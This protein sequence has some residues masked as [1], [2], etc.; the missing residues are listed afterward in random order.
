MVDYDVRLVLYLL[1]V[2]NTIAFIAVFLNPTIL[3]T[4][5]SVFQKHVRKLFNNTG[6][7][8]ITI[9]HKSQALTS[10]KAKQHMYSEFFFFFDISPFKKECL[11]FSLFLAMPCSMWG[12]IS[13]TRD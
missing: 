12:L 11:D 4:S 9:Y 8:R 13:L 1:S 7:W 6:R 3:N 10:S 5:F 2:L